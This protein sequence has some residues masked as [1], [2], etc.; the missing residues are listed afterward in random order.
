MKELGRKLMQMLALIVD[1]LDRWI[2][3]LRRWRIPDA[4]P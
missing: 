2:G 4:G 3:W 1:G